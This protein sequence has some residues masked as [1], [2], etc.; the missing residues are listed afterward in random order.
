MA[1][2][3]HHWKIERQREIKKLRDEIKNNPKSSEL[4]FE[5]GRALIRY[6]NRD[7]KRE[8]IK[9]LEKA[10]KLKTD[11]AE[12]MEV[13][14]IEVMKENPVRGTRLAQKAA[15]IYMSRGDI[16]KTDE[17][18]DK[19]AMHYVYE[20]WDFLSSGDNITAKKKAQRAL[21]IYPHCV[22]ARNILAS[23]HMDRFEFED[24]ERIYKD[25][26][27]DAVAKQGGKLKVE[28][29]TY[30]GSIHTRPYMRS[31]HGLGLCYMRLGKFKEALEEFNTLLDLNPNDNQG[32]RFLIGD[33]YYYMGD[34]ENTAR[35]YRKYGEH[36]GHYNYALLLY[37]MKE[38]SKAIK[39]LKDSIKDAPFIAAMLRT[40]LE[41]FIF[42]Q[43]RGLYN[44][45]QNPHLFMHRNAVINAWNENIGLAK[46]YITNHKLESA[47]DFCN[48]CGSLWLKVNGSYLFLLEGMDAI[49]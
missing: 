22:D 15:S 20:G 45:G 18:L 13:L 2:I 3:I 35:Y 24:A 28:G 43:E 11:F 34:I 33:V 7:S 26:I 16:E 32:V 23:I 17:I 8:G 31:R 5:L 29:V 48:L 12:A 44:F 19:A 38:K 49:A 42:W 37:S 41:M 21:A 10:I 40:Y 36:E 14:A 4:H 6:F 9:Y 47:Y 1:K 46:D 30:W 25:A 39:M 27:R